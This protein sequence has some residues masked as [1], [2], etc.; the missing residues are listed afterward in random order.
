ME[1]LVLDEADQ[2]FDMGF[3]PDVRRIL[4]HLPRKGYQKLLFSATMS[5]PIRRLADRQ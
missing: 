3:L 5:T 4:T 1:V 2:M